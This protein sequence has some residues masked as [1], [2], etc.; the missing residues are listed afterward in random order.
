M[1]FQVETNDDVTI[2][3][4]SGRFDAYSVS[5]IRT[6]I[7]DHKDVSKVVVNLA[8]VNFVDSTALSTLV[9]G[10]KWT[11]QRG[12]DLHLASL[13]QPVHI[14]FELTRLDKAFKIFADLDEAVQAFSV[15]QPA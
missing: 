8:S 10:M 7:S 1:N 11:R 5:E 15:A 12:G 13:Q 3:V 4:L 6:W 2:L 14:I 9:Q